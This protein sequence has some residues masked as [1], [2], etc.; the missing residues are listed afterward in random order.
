[1]YQKRKYC[2]ERLTGHNWVQTGSEL[3]CVAALFSEGLWA[4][5]WRL[6]MGRGRR[7]LR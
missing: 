4:V 2:D 5:G 1:M 6:A 7:R 3:N